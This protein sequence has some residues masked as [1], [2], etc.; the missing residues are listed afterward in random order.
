MSCCVTELRYVDSLDQSATSFL[1]QQL[2]Y[3]LSQAVGGGVKRAFFNVIVCIRSY[4]QR[5][6]NGL[7][8]AFDVDR[9]LDR[10]AG[11]FI[12]SFSVDKAFFYAPA[13]HKHRPCISEMTVHPIEFRFR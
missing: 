8:N 11:T 7:V 3:W 1:R 2:H 5:V 9:V 6:V 10:F 4:T 12:G 13:K